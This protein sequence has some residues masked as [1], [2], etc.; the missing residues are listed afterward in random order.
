[1]SRFIRKSWRIFSLFSGW[2]FFFELFSNDVYTFASNK[3]F[4]FGFI[5]LVYILGKWFF[6][7]LTRVICLNYSHIR[8]EGFIK[9]LMNKEDFKR[10]FQSGQWSRTLFYLF[11]IFLNIENLRKVQKIVKKTLKKLWNFWSNFNR[12]FIISQLNFALSFKKKAI[13]GEIRRWFYN[14]I[15]NSWL[16]LKEFGP[17][18]YKICAKYWMVVDNSYCTIF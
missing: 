16:A 11:F 10:H 7:K 18:L 1:M 6:F 2:F 5:L 17:I 15:E 12:F 13:V 4:A 8:L 14:L 9:R 3:S